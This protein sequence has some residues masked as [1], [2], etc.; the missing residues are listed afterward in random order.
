VR[1]GSPPIEQKPVAVPDDVQPLRPWLPPL[2]ASS[3]GGS[4]A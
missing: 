1:S 4:H 3:E 2:A